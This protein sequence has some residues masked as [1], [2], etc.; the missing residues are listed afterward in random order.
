VEL[1]VHTAT[2]VFCKNDTKAKLV[3]TYTKDGEFREKFAACFHPIGADIPGVFAHLLGAKHEIPG[4]DNG[5]IVATFV[6]GLEWVGG[7]APEGTEVVN[8][9][10]T[11][12]G[13]GRIYFGEIVI[14]ENSRR[15][16]LLRFEF[17]SPIGGEG[18]AGECV[19]NG[20]P[21]GH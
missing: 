15:A 6:T 14:E 1:K 18:T 11:I 10:L 4:A 17:G 8:N 20:T 21:I 19:N 9:R 3:E 12:A 2:D 7:A 16:S 13:L 5:P